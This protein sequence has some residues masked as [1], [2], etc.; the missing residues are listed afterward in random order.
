MSSGDKN[1]P[2]HLDE[3]TRAEA[4]QLRSN[5]LAQAKA[6]DRA[7]AEVALRQGM[8]RFTQLLD[9]YGHPTFR[10][11]LVRLLVNNGE[12][13]RAIQLV[14]MPGD[15]GGHH[16]HEILFARAYSAA[17][18]TEAKV[19]WQKVLTRGLND[20]EAIP[21]LIS[22]GAYNANKNSDHTGNEGLIEGAIFEKIHSFVIQSKYKEAAELVSKAKI[23]N[24]MQVEHVVS[25]IIALTYTGDTNR[26]SEII[27][28]GMKSILSCED[29]AIRLINFFRRFHSN[30]EVE[31]LFLNYAF[32]HADLISNRIAER[33]A[34]FDTIHGGHRLEKINLSS[35][36]YHEIMEFQRYLSD[37]PIEY[38]VEKSLGLLKSNR[39]ITHVTLKEMVFSAIS[40]KRPFSFL[41]MGDGEGRFCSNLDKYPLYK[42]ISH[43]IA[44]R[45]WFW[46]S[47]L[48]PPESF[49][50]QLRL[51]YI[52]SD[53]VGIN[54]PFRI[55]FEARNIPIGY[56]GVTMGNKFV[57]ESFD[58][59]SSNYTE[60]W[61]LQ[62]L[63]DGDFF[64]E[65]VKL[66]NRITLI[67]PHTNISDFFL[68]RFDK[69]ISHI[70][71]PAESNP[72]S[73]I[74]SLNRPHYPDVFEKTLS[75][76]SQEASDLYLVAAGA[77]AK[78][79]CDAAR[80]TGAVAIDV[81]SMI[82]KW[83]NINSRPKD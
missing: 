74:A 66:A 34:V 15:I 50:E 5:A 56:V 27:P 19:W 41:R 53:V 44:K 18:N 54:P 68:Q 31:K 81:G 17:R 7:G 35:S 83:M 67:C 12:W 80:R 48:F 38:H 45:I 28:S 29:S 63:E 2:M 58:Q 1:I 77:Y 6:N 4:L 16:W 23:H 37:E 76:I 42:D 73:K 33:I 71:V 72:Y 52:H 14:P 61:A 64:P 46:N 11:E 30:S 78:I 49:F 22:L 51:S 47:R 26:L 65:I 9:E 57:M 21:A 69:N 79:Y 55:E 3:K 13:D 20:D 59:T 8:A 60:N 10:K 70:Q 75:S 39:G 62:L 40:E 25:S 32:S 24:N 36:F 43:D 82:D